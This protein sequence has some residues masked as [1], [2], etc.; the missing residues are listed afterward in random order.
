[1]FAFRLSKKS[2][3]EYKL[4]EIYFYSK[5]VSNK[6]KL[7]REAAYRINSFSENDKNIGAGFLYSVNLLTEIYKYVISKY[8]KEFDKYVFKKEFDFLTKTLGADTLVP[9]IN[10]FLNSFP[11]EPVYSG[12]LKPEEYI[13]NKSDGRY[14]YEVELEDSLILFL[15]NNNP[16]LNSLQDLIG[17]KNL[18]LGNEF[19]RYSETAGTFFKTEPKIAE[20]TDLLSFLLEPINKFPNNLQGQLEFIKTE[21]KDLISDKFERE[22]LTG[23]DLLREDVILSGAGAPPPTLIPEYI[24]PG[25]G[26]AIGKSGFDMLASSAEDYEEE[27]NFTADTAWMPKVVMIAKNT[28]VWLSQ[29]S[30]KY[31]RDIYRLDHVPDEELIELKNRNINSLWLIGVWQRSEASEKIKHLRGN[32]D[33]VASAYS[34]Y[35]YEIASDLGGYEAYRNL[36]ERAK[37]FGIRLA[38]DMVPNHTG[39]YS[40]WIVEHPDYFIQSSMP[41]FPSYKFTGENLSPDPNFSIKIEDGYWSNSDAAVVFERIDNRTGERRYIYH[42]NDG[43]NMPWNDTAQLDILKKEVREAVIQKIMD[44]A[45][46]FSIIRFDAAMTLTKKHFARL[47][48]PEPGSGGDIPSRADYALTKEEF[49]AL[50][51]KEFWREVV[52]RINSE[53]PETLL[54]AEAFWL[55]EGYFVRTLGMHRVYN[56]AFMNMLMREENHK[57]RELLKNTLEFEPEILK[58]YVNFM[59]NPDEETAIKQFGAGDKYFGVLTMMIT[60]PGLPMFAHGQIEGYHEKYGM[61]YKR[62]YYNEEPNT[63]LIERHR[64]EIFPLLR[65]R[66]LFS[67]V[68][69]FWVFPF[70]DKNGNINQNVF[71]YSNRLN[72]EKALVFYNNK[73]DSVSGQINF[74]EKKLVDNQLKL[75]T[76][77]EALSINPADDIFISFREFIS[78]REFLFKAEDFKSGFEINLNGFEYRVFTD[79]TTLPVT[80]ELTELY[81]RVGKIGF[82]SLEDEIVRTQIKPIHE[83]TLSLF[84][85]EIFSEV[86]SFLST[87]G[88]DKRE[89]L[90]RDIS[91]LTNRFNYLLH[92]IADFLEIKT[93]LHI[94]E[95]SFREIL[96]AVIEL[97]QDVMSSKL[98]IDKSLRENLLLLFEHNYRDNFAYIILLYIRRALEALAKASPKQINI[99]DELLFDDICITILSKLGKSK[100]ELDEIR[101]LIKIL[102]EFP[103][104]VFEEIFTTSSSS[105]GQK[106]KSFEKTLL[107][108]LDDDAVKRFIRVNEYEGEQF[109]LKENFE[110]LI[111]WYFT[112]GLIKYYVLTSGR[113]I[114]E[115]QKESHIKIMSK[116]INYINLIS[117]DSGYRL[118]TLKEKLKV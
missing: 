60:M 75:K 83:A 103:E 7:I 3:L 59:S 8:R 90:E 54:L 32:I 109:Y 108:M 50:F 114:P 95:N 40:K 113:E 78:G 25:K 5:N 84:D 102:T 34:L 73:Y 38:A 16:A 44:V 9:V 100:N 23:F 77:S 65:K 22:F 33:A 70:I 31:Q 58:R 117:E 86:I 20:D 61:E 10:D 101:T 4:D 46:K 80:G 29:L 52:D 47:W 115:T 17:I 104:S 74:S 21:W 24:N 93:D 26:A 28:Y 91:F 48:Y 11:P 37:Q 13:W 2:L 94:I 99:Y 82:S 87:E 42:G 76:L 85:E 36:N 6:N 112:I 27:E 98:Q 15:H 43:T 118:N 35:D 88:L 116:I 89:N 55:M 67:E 72:D 71:A 39:I 81:S 41:P 62:A 97:R 64:R 57:Y 79:F 56:S 12:R 53:M 111:H 68:K 66:R 51:P 45:R 19:N 18:S 49:N 1:M 106:I 30:R 63:E 107:S 105:I 110:E 96:L 69:N 14:N 92:Q